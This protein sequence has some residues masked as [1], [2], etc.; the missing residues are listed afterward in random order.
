MRLLHTSDWHLGI[1]HGVVSRAPD[2]DHMLD[3]LVGQV[4]EQRIDA[5]ILAGDVFD[6]MQPSAD[7]LARYY[8]FLSRLSQTGLG[9][10]VVIGGNH[11]NASRLEAPADVLRALRVHVVGGITG[12]DDALGRCVVPLHDRQGT[13]RAVA[14]AVPFVHEFRLGVR[15]TDLDHSALRAAFTERF[16]DLYRRLADQARDRWPDLPLVATGHL[17]LGPARSEDYPQEI[18]QVGKIDGLPATIFDARIQY[19][20]LG[21]IHRSYPV[22]ADRRLWYSGSP[23]A[24]SLPEARRPRRMLKVE[25]SADLT[26]PPQVEPLIVPSPRAL[27]E[28]RGDPDTLRREIRGLTWT[29]P[30][31]PLLFLRAVGDALPHDVGDT[32]RA[33]IEGTFPPER[34]PIL[35]ELRQERATPLPVEDEGPRPDLRELEPHQVFATLCRSRGLADT[36]A[37]DQAFTTLSSATD[38]DLAAMIAE[39]RRPESA[40]DTAGSGAP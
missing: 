5:L 31:P 30:L 37:L 26:A 29:E 19:G 38:D 33:A 34:R 28:L 24:F 40:G 8:R 21:H 22:D 3:W 13:P 12:A 27:V 36:Q 20:A 15:T 9:Q 17:T 23:I 16:A 4:E 18:H 1:R 25:L 39:A 10:V 6:T 35:A 32:L 11:D 7:A 2:H 14:L